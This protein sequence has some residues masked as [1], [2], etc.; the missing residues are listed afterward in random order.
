VWDDS[1][2]QS[3]TG[4]GVSKQ[5]PGRDVP[6]VAGNADPDSGYE[7]MIDGG[8]YVIGGTSAVAPL[9]LGLH[10]LLWECNGGK[11]FDFL[12]LIVT[13]PQ[14]MFDVTAGDNGGY[15]AGPGRDQVT[16]FGVPDGQKLVDALLGGVPAPAPP[17]PTPTPTPTPAG[18][19]LADFPVAAVDALL[20]VKHNYNHAE[21]TAVQDITEWATAHGIQLT[22]TPT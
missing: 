20:E 7:I 9:M 22:G 12:N 21:S 16:G 13:N 17:A 5:F 19:P 11:L 2:T 18:D 1:D 3:A 4:G 8:H 14:A 15:R 6:D 10:A